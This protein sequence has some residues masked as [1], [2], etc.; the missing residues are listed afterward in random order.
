MDN[1]DS[2]EGGL[3]LLA[4]PIGNLG[5][6]TY[7]AV[8][9]LQEADLV[10]AEDTRR[11]RVLLSHFEISVSTTSYH[12]HNERQ[13]TKQ[14]LDKV[15]DGQ[16]VV[17][18]SDA[19]TPAIAD[20]GFYI[21][22]EAVARGIEPIIIPGVSALTFAAVACAFPVDQFVFAGFLPVKKGKRKARL[23][24]LKETGLTSFVFE[25]PYKMDKLLGEIA[26]VFGEKAIIAVTREA[27][28]FYEECLRGT[29]TEIQALYTEKKWKGEIVVAINPREEE[30][31]RSCQNGL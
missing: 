7:R 4:T 8:K 27:T 3:Y 15:Q 24:A 18:L 30:T 20:P 21:V 13:K 26:E 12:M 2:S 22:R 5:D 19:G 11:A 9:T 1:T 29:V 6:I 23:E 28:K 31:E 10:A 14:L 25:S 16:K 17:V